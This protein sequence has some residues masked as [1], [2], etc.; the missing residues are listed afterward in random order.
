MTGLYDPTGLLVARLEGRLRL[1]LTLFPLLRLFPFFVLFTFLTG[2][3]LKGLISF[4]ES[5]LFGAGF[6]GF[7]VGTFASEYER[8]PFLVPKA[9]SA[10]PRDLTPFLRR[11]LPSSSAA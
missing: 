2:F 5:S 8:G 11:V 3:P 9:H 10:Q 4:V 7:S 1:V 6:H